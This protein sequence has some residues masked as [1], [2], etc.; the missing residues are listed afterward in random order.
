MVIK[1]KFKTH[2]TVLSMIIFLITVV[3]LLIHFFVQPFV[4]EMALYIALIL[5]GTSGQYIF[6]R[7]RYYRMHKR[8]EWLEEKIA[9]W[10][11]MSYRVNKAGE[12]AFNEFPVAVLLFSEDFQ[13]DWSNKFAKAVFISPL[14]DKE[15]YF[16]HQELFSHLQ[17]KD[18]EFDL[19]VYGK[20]Y[21][22]TVNYTYRI[23]YLVDKTK[24][25]ELT[26]EMNQKMLSIGVLSI[27][28]L[29]QALGSLDAQERAL[30][31]SN[32]IGILSTWAEEN[33]LYLRGYSEDRYLLLFSK[34][35]LFQLM[36][37]EFEVIDE[38]KNYAY[39][40]NLRISV[41]IGI[42]CEDISKMKLVDL[43]DKQ[44]SLALSRG[45]DQ[46]VVMIDSEV[47]YYGARSNA[48]ETRSNVYTRVKAE[49]LSALV[50]GASNVIIMTH[51]FVDA[52]AFGSSIGLYK[53]VE[54]LE[55]DVH[56]VF[57]SDLVD[58]TVSLIYDVI[59]AKHRNTL[60]ALIDVKTALN[61]MT[62]D[63]LLIITDTQYKNLLMNDRIY[64]QA[65]KIAIIDHHRRTMEAIQNYDF[66]YVQPSA[67][68]SVEMVTE[69]FNYL[70]N[71]IEISSTEATWMLLGMIVDTNNFLFRTSPQTYEV[72]AKLH[73]YGA[74]TSKVKVYLREDLESFQKKITILNNMEIF[75]DKYGIAICTDEHC[76]RQLLAKIADSLISIEKI[77]AGFAIGRIEKNVIG[78]S[79]RSLENINVQVVMEKLG[80]GGHFNNAAAQISKVTVEQAR[81]MLMDKLANMDKG[82]KATMKIILIKDVKGKGKIDDIIEVPS[83][84]ANFLIR[85][86]QAIEATIDNIK[87]L[88]NKHLK[89]E[90]D[91]ERLFNQMK[92]LKLQIEARAITIGVKVGKEGKLFGSVS[93]KQLVEEF[94]R[95]HN[96]DLDK[97]K[98][99]S[100][101]D[102]DALGTYKIPIQLHKEVTAHITLH[103]IE[104]E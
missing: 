103:V 8:L 36:K 58:P 37:N 71:E 74:E 9:L 87:Q 60:D 31:I 39:G 78:I 10:E 67:S 91:E 33:G 13:I 50:A 85:S 49:E 19:Y 99:L 24:E 41:S 16:I 88:E 26:N 38:I 57:D 48:I 86:N 3:S 25:V 6:S 69:L 65:E 18:A 82:E 44:L 54:A 70:D 84:H 43:A 80:G 95:A 2:R 47:F 55:K 30:T 34:E 61:N 53:F 21:K 46:A 40:E 1:M 92:E 79:A 12:E 22:C 14:L 5:L 73:K 102:I 11:T 101:T 27:D 35:Q 81:E 100:D 28:N 64:Q 62:K 93:T 20:I 52:D 89:K 104:K 15:I 17:K 63:T 96:I 90:Q 76:D 45:G 56:I 97:R 59:E 4:Y 94:K 75:D 77:E 66:L 72:L 7:I 23:I 42:A 51:K 83:G 29:N 68:S 32:I 98:I